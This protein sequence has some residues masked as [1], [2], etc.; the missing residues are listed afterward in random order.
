[1]T[2]KP[3]QEEMIPGGIGLPTQLVEPRNNEEYR[4]NEQLRTNASSEPETPP[5]RG[6]PEKPPRDTPDPKTWI[7]SNA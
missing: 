5:L 4:N 3:E 6:V 7:G 2:A 1:M